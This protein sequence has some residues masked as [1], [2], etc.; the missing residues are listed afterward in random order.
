MVGLIAAYWG[1]Q[2]YITCIEALIFLIA[3]LVITIIEFKTAKMY[4]YYNKVVDSGESFVN[5]NSIPMETKDEIEK[6]LRRDA[7]K[8]IINTLKEGRDVFDTH[9]VED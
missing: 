7:L 5:V 9:K 2:F 6:K 8:S 4:S 3:L 1:T